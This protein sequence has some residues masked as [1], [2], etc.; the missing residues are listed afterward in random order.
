MPHPPVPTSCA[1]ELLIPEDHILLY[2]VNHTSGPTTQVLVNSITR[3]C[4]KLPQ[5]AVTY[6]GHAWNS[7]CTLVPPH[8]TCMLLC[9]CK[10]CIELYVHMKHTTWYVVLLVSCMSSQHTSV[11]R[12]K[13]IPK[14]VL[15]KL[16]VASCLLPN[17]FRYHRRVSGIFRL[18]D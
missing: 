4:S 15:S 12:H 1:V 5:T 11:V 17:V 2:S 8:L 9:L 3:E 10:A 7:L 16:P 13:H 6:L 18:H 14:Q